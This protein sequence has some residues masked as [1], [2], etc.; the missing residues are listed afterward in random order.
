LLGFYYSIGSVPA[1]SSSR[2]ITG[3]SFPFL[4]QTH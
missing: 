3:Y 2:W 4:G 1:S